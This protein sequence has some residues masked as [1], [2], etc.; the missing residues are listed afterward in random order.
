MEQQSAFQQKYPLSK[1]KFWKKIATDLVTYAFLALAFGGFCAFIAALFINLQ[2]PQTYNTLSIGS[3]IGIILLFAVATYAVLISLR[4]WYLRTYIKRYYYDGESFFITIKKGVFA[5][6][7]IHVQYQKIQDVYVD[8]DIIDRLLGIYDVHIASATSTSGIEA[9]IDGVD[10]EVADSLKNH[11]LNAVRNGSHVEPN[12]TQVAQENQKITNPTFNSSEEV[13]SDKYPL[14]GKWMAVKIINLIFGSFGTVVALFIIALLP[15]KRSTT[16]II[17]QF[18]WTLSLGI[19]FV[20]GI[21][22]TVLRFVSL[23]FW[24]KNY[25]FR[26]EKDTLYYKTGVLSIEEKHMP[27]SSI[28]DVN[29]NQSFLEKM[30]GIARVVVENAAVRQVVVNNKTESHSDS[31]VFE[32]LERTDAEKITKILKEIALSKNSTQNGL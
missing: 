25:T 13:S 10:K 6:R 26:L 9:H 14:T 24:K 15:G 1:K 2:S 29:L 23:L 27:Y 28:Q 30:F 21:I 19:S 11:L 3:W 4:A 12:S 7:E 16:N 32:G 31:I 8:Q 22:F 20:L 18:G 5:P 17:D